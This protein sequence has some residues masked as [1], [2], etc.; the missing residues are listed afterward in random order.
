MQKC[1]RE[2]ETTE[3]NSLYL[4][5]LSNI[6]EARPQMGNQ[7]WTNRHTCVGNPNYRDHANV[8]SEMV[9]LC[10]KHH[11]L[12]EPEYTLNSIIEDV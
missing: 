3:E 4:E 5:T 11:I 8:S 1:K 9:A 12:K 2:G 10:I 6:E 7:T